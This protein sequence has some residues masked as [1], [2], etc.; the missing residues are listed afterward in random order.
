[1]E[2][3]QTAHFTATERACVLVEALPYM[4]AYWH[5]I[6]VIKI[7]GSAMSDLEPLRR[8]LTDVVFVEHV[9]VWPVL[10]HGGGPAISQRLQ[11]RNV[12]PHF[13][14]GLRVTDQAT[15]E[16]VQEV[17]ID[18][19]SAGVVGEMQ[20]VDGVGMALN[21]RGSTFLQ[22]RKK[23]EGPDLGFV[24]EVTRVDRA[25]CERL[26]DG[27]VIPVVAPIARDPSGQLYNVNADTA[28]CAIARSL[29][30][31]K[32]IFLSNVSG[33]L[34]DPEQPDSIIPSIHAH[35][36][37]AMIAGGQISGG[38]IPKV[39]ACLDALE[40]GVHKTHIISGL[41]PHALLLEMFTDEGI[42]TQIVM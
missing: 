4:Q 41:I 1:M 19:I 22:G 5:K 2:S 42:G 6:V 33:I 32:L 38:M 3:A 12:E 34:R 28:A 36:V 18:E 30:A 26:L 31:E 15:L 10:V 9:G 39:Q 25:L 40:N 37:R 35:Q 29:K 20:R 27:G 11:E 16:V 17:L 8:F 23:L 24:G 7:G 21:G 14:D 13:V